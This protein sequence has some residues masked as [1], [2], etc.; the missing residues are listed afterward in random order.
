M[1]QGKRLKKEALHFKI[2]GKNIAEILDM[3]IEE[4]VDFFP[5][6]EGHVTLEVAQFLVDLRSEF[7]FG[8]C[9]YRLLRQSL[10]DQMSDLPGVFETPDF[11]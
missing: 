7:E 5:V 10:S 8:V 1:C 3:S 11:D 4:G 9:F 6:A 2:D